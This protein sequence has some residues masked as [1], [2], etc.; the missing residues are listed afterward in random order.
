MTPTRRRPRRPPERAT[1][2]RPEFLSFTEVAAFTGI[3]KGHL[4]TVVTR[5]GLTVYRSQRDA[6]KRFLTRE[7]ALRLITPRLMTPDP[8]P[9]EDL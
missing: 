3:S 5:E 9:A 8:T 6:R 4:R 7:D 2:G 1:A